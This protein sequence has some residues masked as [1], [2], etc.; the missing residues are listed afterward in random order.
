MFMTWD[1]SNMLVF[2]PIWLVLVECSYLQDKYHA[3]IDEEI[4]KNTMNNIHHNSDDNSGSFGSVFIGQ[5]PNTLVSM[6]RLATDMSHDIL[7]ALKSNLAYF[8][9]LGVSQDSSIDNENSA[10]R[11]STNI[12]ITDRQ[13][14]ENLDMKIGVMESVKDISLFYELELNGVE[15]VNSIVNTSE[16]PRSF[17]E[18]PMLARRVKNYAESFGITKLIS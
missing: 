10:D 6:I 5:D 9:A 13:T 7:S 11:I 3:P 17:K 14:A 15:V 2:Y 18:S 16:H 12:K 8:A 1:N 4:L